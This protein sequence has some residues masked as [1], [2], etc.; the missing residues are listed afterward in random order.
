MEYV[1]VARAKGLREKTILYRH[2]IRNALIPMVTL[3]A[4]TFPILLSGSVIVETVFAYP[5]MG[6]LLYDS[7]LENDF[8]V[9]MAILMLLAVIVVL[10]N[11]LADIS[12]GFLD[13]R[14]RV[15]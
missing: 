2:A 3:F 5:G 13:P 9:S 4:N 6:K 10:F 15:G 12:Y 1:Q 8:A 11:L 14:V 7:V